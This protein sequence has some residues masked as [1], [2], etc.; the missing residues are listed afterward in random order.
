MVS[1]RKVVR[2]G[3]IGALV[4]LPQWASAESLGDALTAAYRN[5]N[6][7]EQNRAVLR[8]A[9]EDVAQAVA[10]LRPV[11]SFQASGGYSHTPSFEG[12]TASVSLVA[13][14]SLYD[15]GR[16]AATIAVQKET[17][18]ATRASLVNYEQE[19][20]LDAVSA[21]VMLQQTQDAV[22][23][24]QANV[25]LIG[26]ELQAAKDRFDV[27]EITRTDVAI[28]DAQLAAS[29]SELASAQ[30]DY[31]VARE[32]YK[33]KTGHYPNSLQ[34]LPKMPFTAKG[35][36]EAQAVAR[37]THPTIHQ[38][39][40]QVAA[41]ELGIALA[42]ANM[43]PTLTGKVSASDVRKK[44]SDSFSTTLTLSQTIYNGGRSSSFYRQ[45]LAS[46]DSARASLNQTVAVVL[47]SVGA[48]WSNIEVAKAGISASDRQIRSAQ[49][50]YDGVKEEAKL[51]SRTTLD[52][53]NAEQELLSARTARLSAQA[54]YYIGVYTLLS[55]MGLLTVDHLKLGIATYDPEA[56]YNAVKSAPATS[57]QGKR[58]DRVL[59]SIGKY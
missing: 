41:A 36:A 32:T 43:G 14:M 42:K 35:L 8:S 21:Y 1:I 9:D 19:V 5:S 13:E 20:L 10:L 54:S 39:Q 15:F 11:L 55:R 22:A 31:A 2:A 52:V 6:L 27:G 26:Q 34:R 49:T 29:Q 7:L 3:L 47:Q 16:N 37:K 18:L 17:V 28:A 57:S 12:L 33:L 56:Y 30:G 4:A 48:A 45:S 38:L 24:R 51:G 59:K 46:R 25:R 53:L 23:L 40:H 50:A 44:S 58:L